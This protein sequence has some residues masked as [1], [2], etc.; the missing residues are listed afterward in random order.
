MG[1]D[2]GRAGGRRSPTY[3]GG[4]VSGDR[5]S[6][7]GRRGGGGLGCPATL[8]TAEQETILGQRDCGWT[9]IRARTMVRVVWYGFRHD[10]TGMNCGSGYGYGCVV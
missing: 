7:R 3:R 2:Q 10:G 8:V 1:S 5:G 6:I 9:R 4:G